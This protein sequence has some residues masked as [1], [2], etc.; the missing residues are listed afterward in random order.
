MSQVRF[1]CTWKTVLSCKQCT[2][3]LKF[4]TLLKRP[5]QLHDT[6]DLPLAMSAN[7]NGRKQWSLMISSLNGLRLTKLIFHERLQTNS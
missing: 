7:F 1:R 2:N 3:Q 5:E 6:A 4:I